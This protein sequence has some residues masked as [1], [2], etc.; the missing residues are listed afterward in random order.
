M[1]IPK[2]VIIGINMHGEIPL[3]ENNNFLKGIVPENMRVTIINAVV[4]GVPNI[5]TLENYENL[6]ETV[7]KNISSSEKNWDSITSSQIDEL[8]ENIKSLL[9]E[10][11]KGQSKE[12]LKHHLRLNSKKTTDV[13]FQR[14][15][16]SYNSAFKITTYNENGAIPDKLYYKFGDGEVLNPDN[17]TEQYFNQ[18]VIY[19]LQG[20]PDVFE[21][22][23]TVGMEIEEIT[24][25]QLIEFFQ[26][27]G[28]EKMIIVDLSCSSFT[29][30]DFRISDRDIRS[31]R[32]TLAKGT[33]K[34]IKTK[35]KTKI[36]TK[37][38]KS[39]KSR[40]HKKSRKP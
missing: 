31:M 35:T 14:Y 7:S 16:H 3:K 8:S 6:A 2:T 17:I 23:K 33:N 40:R 37:F 24:T 34:K 5:S 22:L 26:S 29:S 1:D 27:L 21:L 4:P 10:E 13:N 20:E 32:R 30:K 12:I 18:I 19:N 38:N 11:N 36:K 28:V 15:T 39:Q 25:L 9:I